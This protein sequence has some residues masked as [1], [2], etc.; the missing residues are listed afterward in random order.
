MRR[1]TLLGRAIH[2]NLNFANVLLQSLG[3][4]ERDLD[5]QFGGIF[6]RSLGKATVNKSYNGGTW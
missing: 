5:R 1:E 6:A 2:P 3:K 4:R